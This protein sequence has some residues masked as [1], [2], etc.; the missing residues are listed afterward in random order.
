VNK[1]DSYN[2]KKYQRQLLSLII[3]DKKHNW[4]EL[5]QKHH[6]WRQ[7][8][9]LNYY[10]HNALIVLEIRATIYAPGRNQYCGFCAL[11]FQ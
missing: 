3:G 8:P 5:V 4:R 10:D 11:L 6:N 9:F 2:D 7:K 1:W